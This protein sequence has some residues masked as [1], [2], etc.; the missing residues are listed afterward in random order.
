MRVELHIRGELFHTWEYDLLEF[1]DPLCELTNKERE[2]MWAR[3]LENCK[4][5]V[6]FVIMNKPYE[7]FF[8]LPA[9]KQP[10]DVDLEDNEKFLQHLIENQRPSF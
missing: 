3:I 9:R 2:E 5:E 8:I 6:E 4:R 7:F 10:A 1:Y